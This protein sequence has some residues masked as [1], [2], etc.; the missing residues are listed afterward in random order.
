MKRILTTVALAA[1]AGVAFVAPTGAIARAATILPLP[2]GS[3]FG[4]GTVN[5][6]FPVVP[7]TTTVFAGTIDG[8]AAREVYTVTRDVK[9]IQGVP[10]NVIRDQLYLERDSGRGR[11]L[12][13]DTLDWY[14]TANDGTVWYLGED[15]RELDE[16]GHVTSTDG[17]WQAGV[18]GANA[19]IFMP[20]VPQVGDVYPQESAT[21]AQDLFRITDVSADGITTHE[22]TPLEPGLVTRKVYET[23]TGQVIEDTV[24]GAAIE[25]LFLRLVSG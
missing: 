2:P 23:G 20:A 21:D 19:G 9:M 25:D 11:Y 22:W 16:Q 1:A 15:T 24:K 7:G 18:D 8:V 12:A 5:P 13:E 14:A 10:A 3:S 6:W 4:A 17:S